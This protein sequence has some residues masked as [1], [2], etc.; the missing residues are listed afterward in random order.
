MKRAKRFQEGGDV[1]EKEYEAAADREY[2]RQID[3]AFGNEGE[4][5]KPKPK[6]RRAKPIAVGKPKQA[7]VPGTV[8]YTGD[9]AAN[10]FVREA[11]AGRR[12]RGAAL[13]GNSY[14]PGKSSEAANLR[15]MSP[16]PIG[17]AKGGYVRSADG[18][19]Q[20]GKTKGTIR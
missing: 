8:M 6:A 18:C 11:Q 3:S 14:Q 13:Y 2:R 20:R 19:C 10:D 17:Y 7:S 5:A 4:K 1:A 12:G 9:E 15:K 16:I